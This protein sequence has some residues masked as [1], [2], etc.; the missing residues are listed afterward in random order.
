MQ[1]DASL[2]K[3]RKEWSVAHH[4]DSAWLDF[5]AYRHGKLCHSSF[6]DITGASPAY[7]AGLVERLNIHVNNLLY[8][9]GRIPQ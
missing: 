4:G 2:N 8:E 1:H 6:I 9:L 3:V 5:V 7:V